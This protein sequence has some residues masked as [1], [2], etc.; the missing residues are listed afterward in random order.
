MERAARRGYNVFGAA[1]TIYEQALAD[2]GREASR[3][4]LAQILYVHVADN[5]DRAWDEAQDGLHWMM[6]LH[7]ERRDL[8][9]GATQDGPL[10]ELPPADELRGIEGLG[11]TPTLSYII[12]SPE[13]VAAGLLPFSR[14]ERGRMTE[15]ALT[16]HHPGMASGHVHRSMQLFCERVVPD[17]IDAG[18]ALDLAAAT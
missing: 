1:S 5:R 15:L 14:G 18:A 9:A 13:E 12:G 16:F 11:F 6:R 4:Q 10:E 2:A 3:Q 8:L 17:L 7:R